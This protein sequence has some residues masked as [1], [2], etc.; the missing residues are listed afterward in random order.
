VTVAAT[1]VV[2]SFQ[3]LATE[4]VLLDGRLRRPTTAGGAKLLPIDLTR[5]TGFHH[6]HIPPGHDYWFG[7]E[8][9]KLR[10]A[11]IE[12]MLA[13]LRGEGRGWSGQLLFSDGE[14]LR[15][16]Y[17]VYGWLDDLADKTVNSLE[18]IA[19]RP[20]ARTERHAAFTS[21]PRPPVSASKTIR[22]IRRSPREYLEESATGPI[23]VGNRRYLPRRAV[24]IR[25]RQ[26]IDTPANRRATRVAAELL[27]LTGF[28]LDASPP[29]AERARCAAWR[30]QLS[31]ILVESPLAKVAPRPGEGLGSMVR[32]IEELVDE[33][34][35]RTYDTAVRLRDLTAW[36]PTRMPLPSYSYVQ[37]SDAIYQAFVA[38]MIA[39]ALKLDPTA[40][41]LGLVQPA[42]ASAEW[43]LYVNVVPPRAVM[44]SWRSYTDA[45]DAYRPDLTLVRKAD[46]H[47]VL[48]DAK[49][50][51]GDEGASE[52]ARREME[53]YMAAF[54][55]GHVAVFFPVAPDGPLNTTTYAWDDRAISEI[56]VAPHEGLQEWLGQ[57]LP[58]LMNDRAAEPPWRGDV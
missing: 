53:S 9:A 25:R 50:R 48:A 7:T 28:V 5:S 8:D 1:D 14:Y 41:A 44:R 52:S 32:T 49:Y 47:V 3:G 21:R 42:F 35:R 54:G 23:E 40:E 16:P 24:E 18:A 56:P 2:L 39:G 45:P 29:E 43:D 31:K 37:Y 26:A 19:H 4:S 51:I 27:M 55:L 20:V 36:A 12:Q 22:A 46:T 30:S 13:A 6:I 58:G 34:Y 11:G 33:R 10:H 57:S 38:T 17:V 15:D